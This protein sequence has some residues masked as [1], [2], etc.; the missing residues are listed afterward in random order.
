MRYQF[1]KLSD[2]GEHFDFLSYPAP[3][4]ALPHLK[5]ELTPMEILRPDTLV[6]SVYANYDVFDL[7]LENQG[8]PFF[9]D[10]P[11]EG[12]FLELPQKADLDTFIYEKRIR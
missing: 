11:E 3:R 9:G 10:L 1:M 2:D 8:L 6:N 5:L 12:T 7:L 4:K